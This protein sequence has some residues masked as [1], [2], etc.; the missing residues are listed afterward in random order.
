MVNDVV[1]CTE[2]TASYCGPTRVTAAYSG[3]RVIYYC[4]G[5]R[6]VSTGSGLAGLGFG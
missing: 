5:Q 4:A 2:P 6:P 1:S 3:G